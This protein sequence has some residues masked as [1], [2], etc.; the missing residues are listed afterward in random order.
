MNRLR[1]LGLGGALIVAACSSGVTATPSSRGP[2]VAPVA[3]QATQGTGAPDLL[4]LR[5]TDGP[6]DRGYAVVDGGSMEPLFS[7][8]VGVPSRDW[9]A[10]YAVTTAGAGTG[11]KTTV[12]A[13]D[14]DG[15]S[16]VRTIE[17]PGT[18][19]LPTIGS[20]QTPAG[21]AGDGRIL[22]LVEPAP[23]ET[24]AVTSSAP[25]P[26][27]ATTTRFAIVTTDGSAAPKILT[28]PGSLEYDA[29]AP[30][31]SA[32]FVLEHV[33]GADP[34]HYVVRSID[35][36]AGRLVDGSIV[37]KRV[38]AEAM[39][40]YAVT[41]IAGAAGNVYTVYRGP[42][43]PFIHALDT[44]AAIAFCID[45]PGPAEQD[46]ATAGAW[47]LTL[48]PSGRS[49]Y[50]SNGVLGTVAEVDLDSF[51]VTRTS[52]L[53]DTGVT[54]A[55]F[56]AGTPLR[57][58]QA[59]LAGDGSTLYVVGKHGISTVR[60]RDLVTTGPIGTD[61]VYRAVA[62]GPDG[63]LYAIDATGA[64]ARLDPVSGQ[65]AVRSAAGTYSGIV[66]VIPHD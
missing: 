20:A 55:K 25:K 35:V 47:G 46:E 12:A 29:L 53:A 13:I 26:T 56:G 15:G 49:I 1:I 42:E 18:W 38:P 57:G 41:Q 8:P 27:D 54:L 28:L 32:L 62:L 23:D 16:L 30:N 11:A 6:A 31:G 39:G 2:S 4:V 36:A 40:G 7:L 50:A 10:L 52:A 63:R 60:T 43:G 64:V 66:A 5:R 24:A 21:L 14:P 3:S 58:G 19:R 65:V 45:L 37:D 17:V 59:T 9:R 22:V 48:A 61:R 34:T 51:S 44:S 33:P